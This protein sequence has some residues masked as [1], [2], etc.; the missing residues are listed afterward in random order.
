MVKLP[1]TL[2]II[3]PI[4]KA[5]SEYIDKG[6]SATVRGIDIT[7]R[8]EISYLFLKEGTSNWTSTDILDTNKIGVYKLTYQVTYKGNTVKKTRVVEIQE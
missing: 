2:F 8:V 3:Q 4:L 1:P 7:N 5:G 6:Y